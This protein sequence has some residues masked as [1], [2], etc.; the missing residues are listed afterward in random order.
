M[1]DRYTHLPPHSVT[2]NRYGASSLIRIRRELVAINLV[3]R[4]VG[5]IGS[6]FVRRLVQNRNH[7]IASADYLT[8]ADNLGLLS[9]V[10]ERPYCTLCHRDI[11]DECTCHERLKTERSAS[12]IHLAA[13]S[14]GNLRNDALGDF[15]RKEAA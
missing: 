2:R 7:R 12:G 5:L 15:V 14:Y 4:G 8:C 3:T 9:G 6:S 10:R 13:V 11:R 1:A